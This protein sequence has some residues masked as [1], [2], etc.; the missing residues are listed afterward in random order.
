MLNDRGPIVS[1]HKTLKLISKAAGFEPTI[2]EEARYSS[3]DCF[4]LLLLCRHFSVQQ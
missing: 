4:M 3:T 2:C 1:F